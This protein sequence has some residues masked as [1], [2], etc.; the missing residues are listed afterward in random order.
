MMKRVCRA[1]R[2]ELS[3][4][5]Q[6]IQYK[7]QNMMISH[8][9]N[10]RRIQYII[11]SIYIIFIYVSSLSYRKS[12]EVDH[13]YNKRLYTSI[14]GI[15]SAV[16][17]LVLVYFI[18]YNMIHYIISII[19][20]LHYI[21][22]I[23]SVIDDVTYYR[24][25]PLH[26]FEG[27]LPS[28]CIHVM[29]IFHYISIIQL[30]QHIYMQVFITGTFITYILVRLLWIE[31]F[32]TSFFIRS[33]FTLLL[34][35]FF[36]YMS[37]QHTINTFSILIQK[38]KNLHEVLKL[39][40]AISSSPVFV[41]R[42]DDLPNHIEYIKTLETSK[43]LSY[44]KS[45]T[46]K[47][48]CDTFYSYNDSKENMITENIYNKLQSIYFGPDGSLDVSYINKQDDSTSRDNDACMKDISSK[49]YESHNVLDII[50]DILI[51][52]MDKNQIISN[53]VYILKNMD[54]RQVRRDRYK[55]YDIKL[56]FVPFQS[57]P[58]MVIVLID[59]SSRIIMNTLEQHNQS[60]DQTLNSL[61]HDM[62][63]PLHAIF[64]F[65]E[66][67][68]YKISLKNKNNQVAI[69]KCKKISA[70]CEHLSMLVN[71]I[72]D[73]ARLANGK[74][75]LNITQFDFVVLAE[76]CIELTRTIQENPNVSFSYKGPTAL[77]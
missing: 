21:I 27:N 52:Q 22:W 75:N 53:Y 66:N 69:E 61:T 54:N 23:E 42:L 74:F 2:D 10:I 73:S 34:C 64:G 38:E 43:V 40:D 46:I 62:R 39:I 70:N 37:K 13:I 15:S 1:L 65:V 63:A 36:S 50:L 24:N 76:E 4:V 8:T 67:L 26:T 58:S 6:P 5:L 72:L 33:A 49:N 71:D 25:K 30:N 44:I 35:I 16:C 19:S 11:I 28:P 68:T 55:I 60:M 77:L 59:K 57:I 47:Y 18:K 14:I 45:T 31:V 56:M 32:F 17:I 7:Y 41:I 9:I 3:V 48:H 20:Y 51:D 12:I 29:I